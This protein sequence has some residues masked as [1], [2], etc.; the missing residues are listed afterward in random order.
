MAILITP[1]NTPRTIP[2]VSAD[3]NAP[4]VCPDGWSNTNAGCGDTLPHPQDWSGRESEGSSK[5]LMF[6]ATV[7]QSSWNAM[8]FW[9]C[10]AGG[11]EGWQV[12]IYSS[13]GSLIARVTSKIST[14]ACQSITLNQAVTSG[15][16]VWIAFSREA[17]RE[18]R[19]YVVSDACR[20]E[21]DIGSWNGQWPTS[22]G[23]SFN[24][25]TGS[26]TG[27]NVYTGVVDAVWLQTNIQGF[28]YSMS[29]SPS[30]L[31][32]SQNRSATTTITLTKISGATPKLVTLW[33]ASCPIPGGG[34]SISGPSSILPNPTASTT[35]FITAGVT[36]PP[37]T[38]TV[39]I[40][41][42]SPT[43]T[44]SFPVLVTVSY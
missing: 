26:C 25:P 38:Y 11:G 1:L 6:R 7:D 43:H 3:S 10:N 14:N 12:G 4:Y 16:T 27:P 42:K 17:G 39:I 41:G 8:Y 22:A 35:F 44:V 30:L 29:Y 21:Y 19:Q 31:T 5:L 32:M 15:S 33:V 40:E 20:Y 24:P 23:G 36:T 9:V 18:P 37:L 28:D 34:C 2:Q 13:T